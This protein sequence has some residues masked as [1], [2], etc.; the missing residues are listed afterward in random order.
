[1]IIIEHEAKIVTLQKIVSKPKWVLQSWYG[2]SHS[3]SWQFFFIQFNSNRSQFKYRRWAH[4]ESFHLVS[5]VQM[6]RLITIMWIKKKKSWTVQ[7]RKE[8]LIIHFRR[9]ISIPIHIDLICHFI[10]P[11]FFS[12]SWVEK[13]CDREL[14][15]L[16]A[17]DTVEFNFN[18]FILSTYIR[19]GFAAPRV[20]TRMESISPLSELSSLTASRKR[21]QK[22]RNVSRRNKS[23]C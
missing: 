6:K 12:S 17:F 1:M 9:V 7:M 16:K 15:H 10:Q 4:L 3:P 14:F 8:Q 2:N 5:F 18:G 19:R 20:F 23:C 21:V 11:F 22:P 13:I